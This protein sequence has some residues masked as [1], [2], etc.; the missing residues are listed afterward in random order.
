LR[1]HNQVKPIRPTLRHQVRDKDVD[2]VADTNH[3]SPRHKSCRRLSGFVSVSRRTL[4]ATFP[5]HCNEQNSIR[6]T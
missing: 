6:V 2:F 1:D 5:V 3:E 4:S